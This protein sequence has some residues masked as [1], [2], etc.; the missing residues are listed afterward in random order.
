MRNRD[1]FAV[2]GGSVNSGDATS[3]LTSTFTI[4][5]DGEGSP[6][7][8]LQDRD[9]FCRRGLP[10][11]SYFQAERYAGRG[12]DTATGH[13]GAP[14]YI[15][16]DIPFESSISVSWTNASSSS[17][18][19]IWWE[20]EYVDDDPNLNRG[21]RGHLHAT[22]ISASPTAYTEQTLIDVAGPAMLIGLTGQWRGGDGNFNYQEGK[23]QAYI[24][25]EG[26]ASYQ[27]SGTEDFFQQSDYAR[28][29]GPASNVAFNEFGVPYSDGTATIDYYRWLQA[30]PIY[31]ASHLKVTWQNGISSIATVTNPTGIDLVAWY[32]TST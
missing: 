18:A 24:D 32:Y 8:S 16:I 1:G 9:L 26:T 20:I 15:S 10:G 6:S 28:N 4:T 23:V 14:C 2:K 11:W 31:G 3:V 21:T 13:L 25:S 19:T 27:S 17:T 22:K 30:S 29:A 5:R 12:V 7:I